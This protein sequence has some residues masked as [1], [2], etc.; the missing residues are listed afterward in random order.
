MAEQGNALANLDSEAFGLETALDWYARDE[1]D[2]GLG[3]MPYPPDYP[4]MAGEPMRVQPS[5][6]KKTD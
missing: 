3:E 2:H 1:R 4:K 6:A 5:R